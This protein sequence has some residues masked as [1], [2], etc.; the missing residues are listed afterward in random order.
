MSAVLA[1]WGFVE[2]QHGMRE[3]EGSV[4]PST[5]HIT[6]QYHMWSRSNHTRGDFSEFSEHNGFRKHH[7][8]NL[9]RAQG[10]CIWDEYLDVQCRH[11]P[12][13]KFAA[14]MTTERPGEYCDAWTL[15]RLEQCRKTFGLEAE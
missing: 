12:S 9:D 11:H 3:V 6:P 5:A 1:A 8:D 2:H 4:N 7:Q 13:N 14:K 15:P 10:P